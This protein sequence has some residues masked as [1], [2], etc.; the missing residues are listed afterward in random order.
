M[1]SEEVE[2]RI[3]IA[4]VK[5]RRSLD[6]SNLGLTKIPAE[7]NKLNQLVSLDLSHNYLTDL[8][9]PISLNHLKWIDLSQN[10]LSRINGLE[11]LVSLETLY[12]SNNNISEISGLENQQQLTTLFL[13]YNQISEIKNLSVLDQ[14]TWLS[15]AHNQIDKIQGLENLSALRTL[16]LRYNKILTINGLESLDQLN[17]LHIDNNGLTHTTGLESLTKLNFLDLSYN[18][19]D[20]LEALKALTNLKQLHLQN[21]NISKFPEFLLHLKLP[22]IFEADSSSIL[23]CIRIES[24]PVTIPH[25]SIMKKGNEAIMMYF[26]ESRKSGEE[27]LNEAKLILLGDGRAGK[28]SFANSLLGKELPKEVDRT[29]GVEIV[30]GEYS[31]PIANE[32]NFK[33]NIWDFAGHDKYKTLHQ[34][35]YTESS[36]YVMLSESGSDNTDFDDWFQTAALFGKGSPLI[37]ILNEF[38]SGIGLGSFDTNYWRKQFPELLN[39]VFT[40]NLGTRENLQ[41]A[42]NYIQLIAQTLPHTK[43]ALPSNWVAVRRVLHDRR[44]QQFITLN[45]YL[46]IC[47]ENDVP[48]KKSALLLSSILHTVGDCLHYQNNDLLRQFIILKN[49]WATDAVYKILDDTIVA[50]SKFGFFDR[51]DL[52]RIWASEEYEDMRPQLLELMK[53]FKLAY[54]LPGREEYVTPPLLPQS[55]PENFTW[56]DQHSLELYIEYEFLPK[57]LLTQF[58]V[59]RHYDIAKERTLVWRHGV[60]LEWP[61]EALAEVSKTKLQGRDALYI[62]AQGA[63]RKGLMTVIIKTFRE[64]HGMYYDGI[65]CDE[66]VPCTCNGCSTR[67]NRQHYFEFANLKLRLEKGKFEVECDRS[68]ETLNVL[69]LLE[70][71]FVLET[72]FQGRSVELKEKINRQITSKLKTIKLFLASSN[73]LKAEREKIERIVGRKNK[74]LKNEGISIE[75][76]IWEDG[77]HIGQSFRSQDNYNLEVKECDLFIL[78]FYSKVGKYTLEEFDNARYLFDLRGLPRICI[79]QK[80][81]DLPKNLTKSDSDSRFAFL[82]TLRNLEHFPFTFDSVDSLTSQVSDTIDKLLDDSDFLNKWIS[83]DYK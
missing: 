48:D 3:Q 66:K 16:D 56:P 69:K 2:N 23:E 77:K 9:P 18:Q 22:I 67:Q 75:L 64:L 53:Q 34:L 44:N 50:G 6:L 41:S 8:E 24:N 68:L 27:Q 60:I 4:K 15:L 55:Y 21:N 72:F 76:M 11:K 38:N 82:E 1:L 62:R 49:T 61:D 43:Y 80:D 58:I 73:E 39:E 28:T 63:N 45:E 37:V 46:R 40:V 32:T 10:K 30:V 19:I 74:R 42:E 26:K 59:S 31:Y 70:N 54:Q 14:I 33:L 17:Q 81:V 5:G 12:L 79:F 20:D 83:V 51:S 36:V 65:K 71:T 7:L 57:A 25:P 52:K 78:L 47:K 13:R 29:K 35:F